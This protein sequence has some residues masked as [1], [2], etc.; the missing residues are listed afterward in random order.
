MMENA[1]MRTSKRPWSLSMVST[2]STS[3]AD[4]VCEIAFDLGV[5][6]RLVV[7]DGEQVVGPGTQLGESDSAQEGLQAVP[8]MKASTDSKKSR[9]PSAGNSSSIRRRR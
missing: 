8:C 9:R 4:A 5:E 6:R 1:V 7:L 2:F 3:A